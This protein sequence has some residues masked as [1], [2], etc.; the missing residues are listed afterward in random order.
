MTNSAVDNSSA[1]FRLD[2]RVAL[3][4]GASSGLGVQFARALR[5]A[6][7]EVMVTARRKERLEQLSDEL[8]CAHHSCDLTS[9]GDRAALVD[10]TWRRFG[11]IDVLVNNAGIAST[12]PAEE[13]TLADFRRVIE[14]N[15]IAPFELARLVG[16]RMLEQQRGSIINIASTLGM[17]GLGQIPDAAYAASKGGL[18]NLTRELAAQ[19]SRRG[20]RVNAIAPGYFETEMTGHMLRDERS[21]QWVARKDPMGRPGLPGELDGAVIFLA[22]D[23]SSYVTGHIL[24][25][26]GGWTAV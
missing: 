18:V 22:S 7:A 17:V 4:T 6:G 14:T 11:H 20:V 21:L 15:L 3:V 23:A 2:G 25:V 24:T 10:E 1:R 16:V 12:K 5:Q 19:W 8:G 13:E 26:D 9:E